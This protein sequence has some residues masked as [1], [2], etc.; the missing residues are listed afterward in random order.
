MLKAYMSHDGAPYENCILV[1]AKDSIHAKKEANRSGRFDGYI[2]IRVSRQPDFDQ[3]A[4]DKTEPWYAEENS[5]LPDGVQF[6]NDNV[7]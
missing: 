4:G 5:D 2:S 1:F 3:Y 6:F 7:I